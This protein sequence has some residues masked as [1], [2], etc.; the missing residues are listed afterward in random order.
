MTFGTSDFLVSPRRRGLRNPIPP[1]F[2]RGYL[3]WERNLSYYPCILSFLGYLSPVPITIELPD[4]ASQAR[5]NL[6]RWTEILADP[7]LAKVP[8]R[9]ETDQHGHL[10]MTPPPAPLHGNRQ[11]RIGALLQQLLPAGDVFSECPVST[12]AGVKAVDVAWL[13]PGRTQNFARLVLFERAPEICVEILSPSNS[14][15]EIDEKRALYFD[16]GAS[17]VWICALDGS[18]SF[19]SAPHQQVP[20]SSICPDFPAHIP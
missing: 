13:A 15:S 3:F 14:A 7:E 16:A 12:A 10:L 1:A 18:I 8:Y 6:D 19:F 2:A 11:I 20:S 9:I 5:F 4:H 17:E